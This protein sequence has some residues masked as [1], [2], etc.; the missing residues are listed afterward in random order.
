MDNYE[1]CCPGLDFEMATS[2]SFMSASI[3]ANRGV[4]MY[5]NGRRASRE[6]Q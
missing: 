2:A 1:Y 4:E 6:A 5:L 3:S